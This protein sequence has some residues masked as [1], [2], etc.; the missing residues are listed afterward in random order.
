[1]EVQEYLSAKTD[2]EL[3]LEL[4]TASRDLEVAAESE[5]NSE[6][7]EA[8]FAGCLLLAQEM[9]KRGIKINRLH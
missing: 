4:A 1:M 7:H 9:S 8:C 5:P 6:W 2:D 3:Q